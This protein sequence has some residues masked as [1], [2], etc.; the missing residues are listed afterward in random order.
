MLALLPE[1]GRLVGQRY[2]CVDIVDRDARAVVTQIPIPRSRGGSRHTTTLFEFSPAGSCLALLHAD[3]GVQLFP[4]SEDGAEFGAP[5]ELRGHLLPV[6]NLRF[7]PDGET[8]ATVGEDGQ[9]ALWNADTLKT[10]TRRVR[11]SS[12]R[13]PGP[14]PTA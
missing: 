2:P 4:C 1:D 13:T 6:A 3:Y 10:A 5:V 12:V 9:L 8:L 7:S 14:W 11:R